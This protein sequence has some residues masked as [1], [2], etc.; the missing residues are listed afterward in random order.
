LVERDT[1]EMEQ[2]Q[3]QTHH[4]SRE[5]GEQLKEMKLAWMTQK[6]LSC[7]TRVEGPQKQEEEVVL[8]GERKEAERPRKAGQEL[9][10]Q[11]KSKIVNARRQAGGRRRG[12]RD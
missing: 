7:S 3:G 6:Q 9:H 4:T 5:V 8:L 1:D 11:Y 2:S 12:E 10:Q